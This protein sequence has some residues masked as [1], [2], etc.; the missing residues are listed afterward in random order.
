LRA[1]GGRLAAGGRR[2]PAV[3]LGIWRGFSIDERRRFLRHLGSRWDVHRHRV[4]PEIHEVLEDARGRG[5]LDVIAGRVCALDAHGDGA[6]VTLVRRGGSAAEALFARRVINCTGPSRSLRSGQSPLLDAV[7]DRG[8]G[9]P[10]PLELGLDVTE[11]GALVDADGTPSDRVFA[12]GPIL[13]GQL[14][15]T[16]AVREL[17]VQA[18]DLARHLIALTAMAPSA[19]RRNPG[20]RNSLEKSA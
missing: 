8:L 9:R 11:T 12:L 16:T 18:H 3:D 2:A 14:W 10:D 4:A 19:A 17:R 13:K 15:E 5:Q 1:R 20:A 7:L 6:E